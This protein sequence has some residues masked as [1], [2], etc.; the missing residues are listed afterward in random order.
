MY[1]CDILFE[2][3]GRNSILADRGGRG[4]NFGSKLCDASYKYPQGEHK[5]QHLKYQQD[6]FTTCFKTCGTNSWVFFPKDL[7]IVTKK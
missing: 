3:V 6:R 5:Y 4:F 7:K 2:G 1:F